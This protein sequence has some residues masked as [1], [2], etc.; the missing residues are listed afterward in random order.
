[1]TW[2]ENMLLLY[3]SH[4]AKPFTFVFGTAYAVITAPFKLLKAFQSNIVQPIANATSSVLR[5]LRNLT[6]PFGLI[7]TFLFGETFNPINETT[8]MGIPTH[9]AMRLRDLIKARDAVE[10]SV[11]QL[12]PADYDRKM[13]ELTRKINDLSNEILADRSGK[14]KNA[15]ADSDIASEPGSRHTSPPHSRPE[16]PVKPNPVTP[17]TAVEGPTG[18]GTGLDN[19]P[20]DAKS[21]VASN[22]GSNAP[23]DATGTV[24]LYKGDSGSEILDKGAQSVVSWGASTYHKSMYESGA[25]WLDEFRDSLFGDELSFMD[26]LRRTIDVNNNNLFHWYADDPGFVLKQLKTAKAW[27]ND[28]VANVHEKGYLYDDSKESHLLISS[29]EIIQY[30]HCP[31]KSCVRNF[32]TMFPDHI[33]QGITMD[34]NVID[35]KIKL[36]HEMHENITYIMSHPEVRAFCNGSKKYELERA[37]HGV[38]RNLRGSSIV[39]PD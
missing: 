7:K 39:V 13:R 9:R 35:R 32:F 2:R 23:T 12:D 20:W 11:T 16:S 14:A 21:D 19:N 29:D 26:V 31:C 27:H 18:S 6:S 28:F 34:K 37:L 24:H 10:E 15:K 3:K 5:L 17:V 22:A 8:V 1:M 33:K 4:L 25:D 30:Q 36:M 38:K